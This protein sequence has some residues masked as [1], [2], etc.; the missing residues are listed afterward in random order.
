M[1]NIII[2]NRIRTQLNLST[3]NN[4]YCEHN[5]EYICK[6]CQD[7]F[8]SSFPS[9]LTGNISGLTGDISRLTGDISPQL[10]GDISSRLTGDISGLTGNISPQLT[11]NISSRLN[12]NISG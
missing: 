10:T 12:G 5:P 8:Y 6:L 3:I 1:I 4:L 7:R 2:E 9:G 11:G